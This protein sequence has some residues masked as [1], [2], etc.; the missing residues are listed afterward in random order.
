MTIG[1]EQKRPIVIRLRNQKIELEP[2][3][4]TRHY[5]E[6]ERMTIIRL[7]SFAG[8]RELTWSERD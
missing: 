7:K 6:N 3:N 2:E 1:T 5:D 8:E 4:G